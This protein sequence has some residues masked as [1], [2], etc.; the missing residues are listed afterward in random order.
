MLDV[1]AELD[2]RH[3]GP[4]RF[5]LEAGAADADLDRAASRLLD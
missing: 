5:L 2:A 4:R 3:G 1:L